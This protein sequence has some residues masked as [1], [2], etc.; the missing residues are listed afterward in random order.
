MRQK[1]KYRK[2]QKVE[3]ANGKN[4]QQIEA[5]IKALIDEL[6]TSH[7]NT[8]LSI[9]A[10]LIRARARIKERQADDSA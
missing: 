5:E 10:D 2:R 6:I 4:L 3:A 7:S 9:R 8:L 1:K